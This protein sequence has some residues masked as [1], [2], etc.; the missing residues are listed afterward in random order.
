MENC[1]PYDVTLERDDILGIM[2]IE[3]EELV[4]LMDD[5]ISS[6]YQ[7]IHNGFPKV[8]RKRLSREEIKQ[9]CHLKVPEKFQE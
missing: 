9:R 5:F 3:E 8:K 6:V 7:D 2:E 1:A 4:P